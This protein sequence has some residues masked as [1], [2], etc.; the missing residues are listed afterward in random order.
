MHSNKRRVHKVS[1][2]LSAVFTLV[3]VGLVFGAGALN[4]SADTTY[5]INDNGKISYYTTDA[6]DPA[7]VLDQ[8]GLV[9]GIDDTYTTE[10][11][12]GYTEIYVQRVQM[13]TINNGGQILKTG[14]YGGSVEDLLAR[15]NVK[16]GENDEISVALTDETFDGMEIVINRISRSVETYSKTLPYETEY[17]E[18]PTLLMGV[19]K[20]I[21]AGSDGEELCTAI[22]TYANGV[23][24][25]RSVLRSNITTKPVNQVIAVGTAVEQREVSGELFI[26]DGVIITQD[27]DVLTYTGTV[28]VL[29]TAYTC[30]GWGRP[31]ITA[32]GTIARV[33]AIAVDPRIIPYG[34]R[35][36]IV[37]DDGE[38]VYGIA[39]A[40]DTGH[41]DF[42]VGHR[43]DLYMDTEYEC[44]QFGARDCTVY[45][46]G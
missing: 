19:E 23:E 10:E 36:F 31:G 24:S 33:G 38:Y 21:T 37:S 28:D 15:L 26:G 29:A 5:R 11:S 2:W 44:I 45:I 20:V 12:N 46:L 22:V 40:E 14:T 39:T 8:A 16:L 42:I 25:G 1:H 17:V 30:E 32:T 27:G 6:T 41:P 43:V 13:V 18:D 4:V 34:T 3:I 35:M 9:L 7:E